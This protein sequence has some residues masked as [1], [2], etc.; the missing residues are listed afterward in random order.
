MFLL[1]KWNRTSFLFLGVGSGKGEAHVDLR[2]PR[3]PERVLGVP[4]F[5]LSV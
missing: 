1:G 2:L 4:G 3:A 5:R